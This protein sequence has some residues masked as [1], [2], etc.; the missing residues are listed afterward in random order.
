MKRAA[1]ARQTEQR[2]TAMLTSADLIAVTAGTNG[3]IISENLAQDPMTKIR[4][5]LV[6]D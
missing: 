3:T 4:E 6:G 2:R 1:I 5:T